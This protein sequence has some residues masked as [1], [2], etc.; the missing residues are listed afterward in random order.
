[1]LVEKLIEEYMDICDAIITGEPN[2][3]TLST[4]EETLTGISDQD[5]VE[6][7]SETIKRYYEPDAASGL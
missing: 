1:M 6:I 5:M 7:T 3:W 2:N 4:P